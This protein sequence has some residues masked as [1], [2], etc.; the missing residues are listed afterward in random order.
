MLPW[1]LRRLRVRLWIYFYMLL[2]LNA[3]MRTPGACAADD[4]TP[5]PRLRRSSLIRPASSHP[6][7]SF[8]GQHVPGIQQG[9][10]QPSSLKRCYWATAGAA[11]EASATIAGKWKASGKTWRAVGG[12]PDSR[13]GAQWASLL[14]FY[15]QLEAWQCDGGGQLLHRR[16][17]AGAQACRY[18]QSTGQTLRPVT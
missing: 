10:T 7:P 16:R 2:N 6:V 13:H 8:N 12:R 4:C 9:Q 15:R 3:L 5:V 18:A 1:S 17:R 14:C 11:A